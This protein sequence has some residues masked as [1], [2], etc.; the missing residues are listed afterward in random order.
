MQ[1]KTVICLKWGTKYGPEYV[2]RLHNMVKRNL[3]NAR[4]ICFTEDPVG[5]DTAVEIKPIP[6]NHPDITG[7]W[8]KLSL[9]QETLYDLAG[10]V[11]FLDLDVVIVNRL[12]PLFETRG[13]FCI[14]KDWLYEKYSE[15]KLNSSVMRFNVGEHAAIWDNFLLHHRRIM[16]RMPGDQDW[17]TERL[18]R[19]T[20]W[21]ENWCISYKWQKAWDNIPKETK[22]VVF[23]GRPNPHEAIGGLLE[24]PPAPWIAN[25]WR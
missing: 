10:P 21:P 24:Y 1:S 25:V 11:L 13:N 17:I 23:H 16:Q 6:S 2:N 12:E 18:A 20:I 15:L 8:L 3:S 22:I 9:F 19:P 4:F 5:I 7:W 14:I